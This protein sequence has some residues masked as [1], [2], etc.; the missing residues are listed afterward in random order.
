MRRGVKGRER[1][2]THVLEQT[3]PKARKIPH[4]S[5]DDEPALLEGWE[6]PPPRELPERL[7][8]EEGGKEVAETGGD[9]GCRRRESGR[10]REGEGE[11]G[12]EGEKPEERKSGL[13]AR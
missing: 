11:K 10:R 12:G 9:V 1:S 2:E 6:D 13:W 5:L 4:R 8:D 3:E 7:T